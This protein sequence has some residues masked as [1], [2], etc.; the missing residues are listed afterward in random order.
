MTAIAIDGDIISIETKLKIGFGEYTNVHYVNETT[1]RPTI[2]PTGA[3]VSIINLISVGVSTPY[4]GFIIS[5]DFEIGDVVEFHG[6]GS[7]Y[8]S[9]NQSLATVNSGVVTIIRK[10]AVNAWTTT[11]A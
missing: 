5:D 3:S 7:I 6:I 11:V 8:S 9:S 4:V 1:E 10:I 2:D